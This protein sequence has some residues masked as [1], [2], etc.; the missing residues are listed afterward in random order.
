[1][2]EILGSTIAGY[3]VM[4]V[5]GE[6]VGTLVNVTMDPATGDLRQF[7]IDP[8]G[9]PLPEFETNDDG[10]VEIPA[11][12]FRSR[13]DYVLVDPTAADGSRGRGGDDSTARGNDSAAR[14]DGAAAREDG[15]AARGDDR[16]PASRD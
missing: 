4:T 15:A 10:H 12:T 13:S 1:M 14:G 5:D 9:R 2:G 16:K 8:E 6:E 7:V 3:S 11:R